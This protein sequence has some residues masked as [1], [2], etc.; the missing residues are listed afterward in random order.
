MGRKEPA[1]GLRRHT[2]D[3]ST[4]TYKGDHTYR[5]MMPTDAVEVAQAAAKPTG[6]VP[7]SRLNSGYAS[8]T[9]KPAGL[10]KETAAS[11][12]T[13]GVPKSRISNNRQ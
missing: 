1:P 9:D 8:V 4:G 11:T 3:A 2:Y 5:G 10:I 7:R 13:G 6:G 12:S